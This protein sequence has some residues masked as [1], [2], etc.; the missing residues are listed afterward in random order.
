MESMT[1]VVIYS[2]SG[3]LILCLAVAAFLAFT[4]YTYYHGK[5]YSHIPSPKKSNFYLG[6]LPDAIRMGNEEAPMQVLLAK[7]QADCSSSI[8]VVHLLTQA[9]VVV[10]DP[11]VIKDIVMQPK[12][13]KSSYM[14]NKFRY[15]FGERFMGRGIFS[16]PDYDVWKPRRRMYDSAFKKSY[17]E[18]IL[19]AFNSCI[20][21]FL[22]KL[23]P[24]TDGVT[25]VPM[26][27]HLSEVT[28][29]VISKVAFGTD[30]TKSW[31]THMLGLTPNNQ[32]GKLTFLIN[33]SLRGL[34]KSLNQHVSGTYSVKF[35]SS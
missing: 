14:M 18:G 3:L 35:K 19:P 33:S 15:L 12:N 11:D 6:H 10:T 34:Q 23:A 25:P 2:A 17:L 28:L 20:D 22:E 31:N 27:E 4:V 26:K 1:T 7:W 8:Y 24:F 16:I 5:K 13:P 9:M 21:L 32:N 29:D 30:F